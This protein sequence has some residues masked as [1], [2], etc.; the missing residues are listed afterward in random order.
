MKLTKDER[1]TAYCIMLA[2]VEEYYETGFCYMVHKV[3][4]VPYDK[5]EH[6]LSFLPE[7]LSKEPTVHYRHHEA[8]WFADKK[9]GWRHRIAI[10]KK[11][12]K[13][14]SNFTL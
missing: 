4:N 11:C 13:E 1:Y 3:F 7:L 6:L 2:E 5:T 14:T 12:I 9:S 8:F 10:L